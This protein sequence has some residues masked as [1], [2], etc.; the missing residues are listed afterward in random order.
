ME[1]KLALSWIK[2]YENKVVLGKDL[3]FNKTSIPMKQ[4]ANVTVSSNADGSMKPNMLNF[5]SFK[6]VIIE[7]TGGKTHKIKL[8][9]ND[10]EEVGDKILELI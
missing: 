3:S 8:R 4:I 6:W 1:K 5:K 2:V 7:T 10:G 9:W